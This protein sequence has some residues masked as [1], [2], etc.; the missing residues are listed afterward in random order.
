MRK[1][2]TDFNGTA[3][4]RST[5]E[6][7]YQFGLYGCTRARVVEWAVCKYYRNHLTALPSDAWV[8]A[9]ELGY[10]FPGN[11]VVR[12]HQNSYPLR[13]G[14]RGI[15][16]YDID[17]LAQFDPKNYETIIARLLQRTLVL[18]TNELQR[19]TGDLRRLDSLVA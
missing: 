19:I 15:P 14:F 7:F 18:H 3:Q 1:I 11:M 4:D 6:T 9:E 12:G 13:V 17:R 10:I 8:R 16:A 2:V 5:I